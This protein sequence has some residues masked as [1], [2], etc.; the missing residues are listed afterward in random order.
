MNIILGLIGTLLSLLLIIYRERIRSIVGNIAW[1]EQHLGPGGTYTA[2][3]LFGLF[4]FFISLTIMT[5]TLDYILG[6][7]FNRF[8]GS[9]KQ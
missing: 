1:A 9:I 8:F 4:G 3:L 7:F 2:L 5:G 6:G